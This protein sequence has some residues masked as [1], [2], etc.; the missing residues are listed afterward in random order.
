VLDTIADRAPSA[1]VIVLGYP[2]LFSEVAGQGL[3][4]L[5]VGDQRWLNAEARELSRVMRETVQ[6]ADRKVVDEHGRGSVEFIDAYGGFAGHEVGSADP[7][8]N[9]L[10]LN[11]ME[12]RAEARSFHPTAAGYRR[13][14]ELVVHQVK[15]GPGRRLNQYR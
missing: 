3:D 5:S 4:N 14:A 12:L 8:V 11:L 13:L 9:G 10:N 2:R 1:R 15:A 7:Y 6:E